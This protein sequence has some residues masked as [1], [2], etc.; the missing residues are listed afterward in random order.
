MPATYPVIPSGSTNGRLIQLAGT[1]TTLHDS[2]SSTSHIDEVFIWVCNTDTTARKVTIEVE[3]TAAANLIEETIP[4][5]SGLVL[6]V[7]G[8]RVNNTTDI[9]GKCET[10]SVCNALVL[11]NR[12][13]LIEGV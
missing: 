5:E 12:H 8:I 10:A 7:P 11:V 1:S 13:V 3:G 2:T 9:D 6:V 4:A